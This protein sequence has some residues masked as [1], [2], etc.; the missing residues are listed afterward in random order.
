MATSC[1]TI[2][3]G[4]ECW[5][6]VAVCCFQLHYFLTASNLVFSGAAVLVHLPD[7]NNDQERHSTS[8]TCAF[9]VAE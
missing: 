4:A 6:F 7:I 2:S 8:V 5:P 3:T 9:I 1:N